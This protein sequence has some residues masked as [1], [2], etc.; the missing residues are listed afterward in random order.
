MD[1]TPTNLAYLFMAFNASFQ[2]GLGNVSPLWQKVA[3]EVP[4]TTGSNDYGWLGQLPGMREWIGDRLIHN[5]AASDYTIKNKKF[6]LTVS[7]PEDKVDDDSYGVYAPMMESLGQ[8][9]SQHP[10]ELLWALLAAGFATS[11]FDGQYYFDTDHPVIQ[12]DGSVATVSNMQAGAGNPWFLLDT[13]R[14]LKPMIMQI[15][16]RPR[17]VRKD[18]PEDD[19]VFNSGDLIYGVDD[20]KNV[21]FGF[22]QMAYA[23]KDTL[24]ATNFDLGVAAM[25]AFKS[26]HG[27]PLGI[28]PNLMVCG[29]SNRSAAKATI[30]AEKLA[31][32]ASNTNFKAVDV[33]VVPWLA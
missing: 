8:S 15:R 31:S 12:A 23:S 24:N 26:D 4:S 10:D 14:P 17:F 28:M 27:R 9:A 18:R 7:V 32:G 33:L 20:R 25:G 6:E 5:L 29:P 21:G 1:L 2:R 3:T 16:R 13:T 22:W 11:C 30:E 19:N